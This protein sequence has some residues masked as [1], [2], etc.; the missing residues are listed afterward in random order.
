MR[1]YITIKDIEMGIDKTSW[2]LP[3]GTK[4]KG[5]LDWEYNSTLEFEPIEGEYKG[6]QLCLCKRHAEE[7][8]ENK[9]VI[10]SKENIID[11]R[12]IPV[13]THAVEYYV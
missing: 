13:H 11:T 7:I 10:E 8:E 1:K 4:G 9:V 2:I 5:K 3:K 6:R 12:N